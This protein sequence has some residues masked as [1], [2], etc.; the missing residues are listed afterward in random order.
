MVP[1]WRYAAYGLA[2]FVALAALVSIRVDVRALEGDLHANAGLVSEALLQNERLHLEVR[3]RRRA[4]QLEREAAA[5]ALV[6]DVA[7]AEAELA[8]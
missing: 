8:R 1:L 6:A 2:F 4:V 5:L 7:H 3:T